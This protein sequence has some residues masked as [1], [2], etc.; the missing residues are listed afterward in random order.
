M[1]KVRFEF[2]V[3]KNDLAPASSRYVATLGDY[4]LERDAGR[5]PNPASAIIDWLEIHEEK[6]T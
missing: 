1:S 4:D 3:V 6:L 2:V 5:G